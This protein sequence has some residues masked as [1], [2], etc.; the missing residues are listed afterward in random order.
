MLPVLFQVPLR[1]L[2][3]ILLRVLFR[4]ALRV[5]LVGVFLFQPLLVGFIVGCGVFHMLAVCLGKIMCPIKFR[6]GT[7][8]KVICLLIIENRIQ[9]CRG[10][11]SDRSGR[12]SLISVCIVRRIHP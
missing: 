3:R 4:V 9:H 11:D 2:L 12:E 1:I 7:E 8:I 5:L 10:S 6:L